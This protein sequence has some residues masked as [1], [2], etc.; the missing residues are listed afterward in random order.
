M[1][2]CIKCKVHVHEWKQVSLYCTPPQ[3]LIVHL[4]RFHYSLTTHLRDK[5]DTLTHFPLT[6]LNLS[7]IVKQEDGPEPM[8]DCYAIS[9]HFGGLGGE[10]YTAYVRADTGIWW[11]F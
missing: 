7:G 10:H 4:K 9:N 5:I 11:N 3:I 6:G 1:W 8:Y 2:Y